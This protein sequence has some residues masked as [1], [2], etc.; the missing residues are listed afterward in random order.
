MRRY[1]RTRPLIFIHVPK[2]AGTSVRQVFGRWFGAGLIDHYFD[3]QRHQRPPLLDLDRLHAPHA[4]VAVYGHFNRLRGFGV[5]HDYPQVGQFVTLLRDPYEAAISA[6][7]YLR[8][9]GHDWHDQSRIPKDSLHRFLLDTPPNILNHFPRSVTRDNYRE[10]IERF[11][12]EVGVMS[13]LPE[14]LRRIARRLGMPFESGMLPHVNA[15]PRTQAPDFDLRDTYREMHPLEH[16]VYR[17]AASRFE[18]A[19]RA[20]SVP[21]R[22]LAVPRASWFGAVRAGAAARSMDVGRTDGPLLRLGQRR[23]GSAIA[24]PACWLPGPDAAHQGQGAHGI[25]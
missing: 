12:I 13:H 22:P 6:Y 19:T 14:S 20:A 25:G 17:Y 11:F 15:T 7:F 24:S 5:E 10:L 9:N 16:E 18:P 3:E 23:R 2:A 4:P 21:I 8:Q 1:D